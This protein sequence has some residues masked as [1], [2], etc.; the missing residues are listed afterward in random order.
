MD[1]DFTRAIKIEKKEHVGVDVSSVAITDHE[2]SL[3]EDVERLCYP[4][5]S[6]FLG[7]STT[8]STDVFVKS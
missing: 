2:Q 1:L 6:S 8:C 3:R 7:L 5:T 4:D